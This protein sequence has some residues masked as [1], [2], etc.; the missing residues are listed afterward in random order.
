MTHCWW[1]YFGAEGD[2][3]YSLGIMA[4]TWCSGFEFLGWHFLLS[5][6]TCLSFGKGMRLACSPPGCSCLV[7]FGKLCS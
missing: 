7:T 2:V 4:L 3:Y 5:G 6:Y 1:F